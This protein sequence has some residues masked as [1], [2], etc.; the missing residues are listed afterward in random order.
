MRCSICHKA[1]PVETSFEN[2]LLFHFVCQECRIIEQSPP[3]LE[4]IPFDKGLIH[5][6][7]LCPKISPNQTDEKRYAHLYTKGFLFFIEQNP[8]N[9]LFLIIDFAE[10]E[11]FPTWGMILFLEENIYITSLFTHTFPSLM[12]E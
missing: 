10:I 9:A 4:S 7:T 12:M 8:S 3:L 2:L 5:W 11:H 6:L 1:I